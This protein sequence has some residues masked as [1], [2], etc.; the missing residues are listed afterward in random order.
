LADISAY[1][2]NHQP[3]YSQWYAGIATD[4]RQ[5]LFSDHN[6]SEKGG[7]WIYRDAGSENGAREVEKRLLQKGCKGGAGGGV[8][9]QYVYAYLITNNT[10]E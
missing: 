2:Q 4:P 9:P 3:Q 10:R 1:I 5:R 8:S 6:T 7:T